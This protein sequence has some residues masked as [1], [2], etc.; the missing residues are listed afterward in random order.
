VPKPIRFACS[1]A[2]VLGLTGCGEDDPPL[3]G[4]PTGTLCPTGVTLTYESFGR[5]F[6]RAFCLK[7]HSQSSSDRNGAP[8]SVNFD[9]AEEIRAHSARIDELAGL[10]PDAE[11]TAMPPS[12][13]I[14]TDAERTRLSQ[15][16][17]CGAP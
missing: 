3:E 16:L 4:N 10:G 12:G 13:L 9:T 15:W 2:L 14:P 17:A 8:G 1:I 5:N 11:N 7:C 6:F